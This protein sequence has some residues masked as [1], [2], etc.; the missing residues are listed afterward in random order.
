MRRRFPTAFALGTLAL[1]ALPL[2]AQGPLS[3]D[4]ALRARAVVEDALNAMGGLQKLQAVN[5]FTIELKGDRSDEGQGMNPVKPAEQSRAVTHPRIT[6]VR[7]LKNRRSYEELHD[8]IF[9]GQP[10]AFRNVVTPASGFV[11]YYEYIDHAMRTIP[12]A[13]LVFLRTQQARRYPQTLLPVAFARLENLRWLG[14]GDYNGRRQNVVAYSDVDGTQLTLYFD[15]VTKLLTKFETP[16]D[17]AVLGDVVNET[18]YSDYRPLGGFTV[19]YR[20]TDRTGGKVQQ[21]M[22]VTRAAIDTHPAESLFVAPPQGYAEVAPVQPTPQPVS[23]GDGVYLV[24]GPYNSVFVVLT[25]YVLVLEAGANAGATQ[26]AIAQIKTT[27][28]GKPIRYVVSTHFHFDHISGV[29]SYIA[30]GSTIV[31]TPQAREVITRMAK[32]AHRLRPDALARAPKEPVFETLNAGQ[33]RV[34]EDGTHRL[35]LYD[36]SPTP[37]VGQMIIGYLPKEKL[38]FEADMLDIAMQG[39]T[40]KA[41]RD[42]EYLARK[43]RELGL[44]VATI[45]PVHGRPGTLDD[46]NHSIAQRV[47]TTKD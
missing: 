38:L 3:L 30:E 31:T 19:P 47:A 42:T 10:L 33:K 8:T 35:K 28:P 32:A 18:V 13:N 45:V 12:P 5:D 9:G 16:V 37:H 17:D 21:D 4:D 7:D 22:V 20:I 15:A 23:M 41:G 14:E 11:V 25:D 43:I 46:L 36:I 6:S 27:A 34:F 2:R 26:A 44:D 1:M 39:H 24:P 29:R 40:G